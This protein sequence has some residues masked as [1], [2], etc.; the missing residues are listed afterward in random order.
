MEHYTNIKWS[1]FLLSLNDKELSC[2]DNFKM[3]GLHWLIINEELQFGVV[4][5]IEALE[6]QFS[7]AFNLKNFD[8]IIEDA[9]W[10]YKFAEPTCL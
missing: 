6:E 8:L 10:R 4:Q 9:F 5:N 3:T 2:L 1:T 7:W